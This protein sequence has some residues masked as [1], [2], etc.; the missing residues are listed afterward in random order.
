MF[1]HDFIFIAIAEPEKSFIRIDLK[2]V[3]TNIAYID[4]NPSWMTAEEFASRLQ[5]VSFN[6]L[7]NDR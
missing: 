1:F 6:L 7:K 2:K 4:V 3:Q 5:T